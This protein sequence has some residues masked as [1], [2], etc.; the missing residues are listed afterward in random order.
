M[1]KEKFDDSFSNFW[2]IMWKKN[3]YIQIFLVAFGITIYE[4]IT[5]KDVMYHFATDTGVDAVMNYI[6]YG[7]APLVAG[8]VAFK[9]MQ[10]WNDLKN[11]RSR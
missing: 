10:F 8:I 7:M 3:H 9:T 1:A 5:I 4:L 11:G 2:T 6:A